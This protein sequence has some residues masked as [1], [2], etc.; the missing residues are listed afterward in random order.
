M[1][2]RVLVLGAGGY[3]GLRL[4]DRLSLCSDLH[5]TGSGRR[6]PAAAT[7]EFK[8]LDATDAT[9]LKR[10]LA[11]TD[12]VVNCV[13]GSPAAIAD[14]AKAL[15]D[16]VLALPGAKPRVVHMSSMAVYGPAEGEVKE[17][18]PQ[19]RGDA[20]HYGG[21][22]VLAEQYLAELEDVVFFRPGCIYGKGSPQWTERMCRLL[23]AGRIGDLGANGD[24]CSNLVFIDDVLDAIV[25]AVRAT[26]LEHQ[27][28]NLAMP[29]APSWNAYFEQM[30]YR[31][32]AVPLK[33]IGSRRLK[34][35]TRLLAPALH[36][37]GKLG[38]RA[39]WR[40]LPAPIPPSLLR[41]W[42]Q[43]IRLDAE[44][45][46]QSLQLRWTTLEEGLRQSLQT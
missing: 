45:A 38:R 3:V 12:A 41:L 31:I 1:T 17:D 37:A 39:G 9:A 23:R 10:E 29:Q 35:E 13:S 19:I 24:G 30:A 46:S 21:A 11:E 25:A 42:R 2:C 4:L 8:I 7:G 6:L 34:L 20:R 40:N 36:V 18:Y 43:D 15:R 27:A 16:A 26:R 44:R 28:Y 14:G 32:G 22:K 33:R 5:A